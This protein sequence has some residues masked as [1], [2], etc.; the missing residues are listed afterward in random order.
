VS[1]DAWDGFAVALWRE[2]ARLPSDAILLLH[3]PGLDW[4]FAQFLQTPDFLRAEVPGD[5][6]DYPTGPLRPQDE[7]RLGEVGWQPPRPRDVSNWWQELPWPA[8]SGEYVRLG[9]AVV[10]A[11]RDV[12]GIATP[13]RLVYRSWEW[14][15]ARRELR[16]PGVAADGA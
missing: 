13:S 16:L 7:R 2:L 15:G 8:T 12:Q 10:T 4:H 3:E 5:D 11:L 1:D 6:P 14:G 9:D